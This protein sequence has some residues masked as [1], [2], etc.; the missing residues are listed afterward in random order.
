MLYLVLRVG[1]TPHAVPSSSA[2]RSEAAMVEVDRGFCSSFGWV[3]SHDCYLIKT[4][5]Y[6][7][8]IAAPKAKRSSIMGGLFGGEKETKKLFHS[9]LLL[10]QCAAG[11]THVRRLDLDT[12]SFCRR[13]ECAVTDMQSGPLVHF[14]LA[15]ASDQAQRKVAPIAAGETGSAGPVDSPSAVAEGDNSSLLDVE[16]AE[17]D[18][19]AEGAPPRASLQSRFYCLVSSAEA[20]R[21]ETLSL[22][23]KI[24]GKKQ[25]KSKS[26]KDG[27]EEAAISGQGEVLRADD[28]GNSLWAVGPVMAAVDAVRWD[29]CAGRCAVL[30]GQ[31]TVSILQLTV[32]STNNGAMALVAVAT[33]N[34]S[35]PVSSFQ[36]IFSLL[37]DRHWLLVATS[38]GGHLVFDCEAI[39]PLQ[40]VSVEVSVALVIIGDSYT[41]PGQ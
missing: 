24:D 11:E 26:S 17:R 4:P 41:F 19:L 22:M 25:K 34:L 23:A 18:L 27:V 2:G 6:I 3:G 9:E 37:W 35:P 20:R 13:A 39:P 21:L 15:G 40:G 16:K 1:D 5:P 32:D 8:P 38:S 33:L 14:N 7:A 31:D 10:F 29:H 28:S 12:Q 30:M 36:N